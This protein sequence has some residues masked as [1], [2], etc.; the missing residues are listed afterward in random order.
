MKL[1]VRDIEKLVG[2]ERTSPRL[3]FDKTF[4]GL[5]ENDTIRLEYLYNRA[6]PFLSIKVVCYLYNF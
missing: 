2:S 1:N 4:N 5:D 6:I 3:V